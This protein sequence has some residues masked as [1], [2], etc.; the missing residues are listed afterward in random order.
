MKTKANFLLIGIM[1]LSILCSC[2]ADA[3]S[4]ELNSY[5]KDLISTPIYIS[6]IPASIADSQTPINIET[7][8]AVVFHSNDPMIHYG[9]IT[10]NSVMN[11]AGENLKININNADYFNNYISVGGKKYNLSNFHFHYHSEHAIDGNYSTMEIH[12]VNIASDNSYAVLGVLVNLGDAN[13]GLEE[14]IAQ[15]PTVNNAIN[16]PNT[17][18]DL[19]KLLPSTSG[20]YT[21]SGSLTTPN[22]GANSSLVNGG[23]VTWFVFKD[24][25]H[26][27]LNEFDSYKSIYSEPNFRSLQPLNNRKVYVNRPG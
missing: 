16:S 26:L 12:F 6:N 17:V 21:Y 9:A 25:Q 2:E 22:F 18:F 7:A 4:F 14:L 10:L 27:S 20:Y 11:N 8:K 24:V 23:P 19:S 5:P 1:Y 13:S 15:S 3:G